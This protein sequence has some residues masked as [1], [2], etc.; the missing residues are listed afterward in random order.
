MFPYIRELFTIIFIIGVHPGYAQTSDQVFDSLSKQVQNEYYSNKENSKTWKEISQESLNS[1]REKE[2]LAQ[3]REMAGGLIL[4]P[5]KSDDDSENILSVLRWMAILSL[6]CILLSILIFLYLSLSSKPNFK[7]PIAKFLG[8][9]IKLQYVLL[10]GLIVGLLTVL[11]CL[12][13]FRP[14]RYDSWNDSAIPSSFFRHLDSK[15]SW[16]RGNEEG[17][18]VER[19]DYLIKKSVTIGSI[20][21][22]GSLMIFS[23][24]ILLTPY[25]FQ[26]KKEKPTPWIK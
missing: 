1:V 16:V 4:N 8:T 7:V 2:R 14:F 3:E 12:L 19:K 20:V 21:M 13:I 5:V 22:L 23:L 15:V 24:K 18:I 6:I 10:G 11:V 26:E 17:S 25:S 9:P